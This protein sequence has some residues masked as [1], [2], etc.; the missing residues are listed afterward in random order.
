MSQIVKETARA[1]FV[2]HGPKNVSMDDVAE[3]SGISKSHIYQLFSTKDA[4]VEVVV[5]DLVASHEVLLA[6]SKGVAND[7]IDEV[8]RQDAALHLICRNLRPRFF[9]DLERFFPM[10]W[11]QLKQHQLNVHQVVLDNLENGKAAGLYREDMRTTVISALRLQQLVNILK[12]EL[13]DDITILYLHSITTEKGKKLLSKYLKKA[14]DG[15]N[16]CRNNDNDLKTL[17]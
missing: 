7:V 15:S 6:A 2:K 13:V 11:A 16:L 3:R 5:N 17:L 4:L 14:E 12:P 10:A 8:L 9:I 1:L